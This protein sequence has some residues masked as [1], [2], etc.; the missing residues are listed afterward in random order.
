[1]FGINDRLFTPDF[2]LATFQPHLQL[3]ILQQQHIHYCAFN[4]QM[5]SGKFKTEAG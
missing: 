4:Q 5:H 1:M 3:V 2:I